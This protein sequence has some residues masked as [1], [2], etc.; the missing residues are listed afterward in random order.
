MIPARSIATN[1]TP[2]VPLIHETDFKLKYRM[3]P[4]PH[5]I[6]ASQFKPPWYQYLPSTLVI[7]ANSYCPLRITKKPTK[8]TPMS[9]PNNIPMESKNVVNASKKVANSSGINETSVA[10]SVTI[11]NAGVSFNLC[12]IFVSADPAAIKLTA[13]AV[14]DVI[15]ITNKAIIPKPNLDAIVEGSESFGSNE[16]FI[17]A[18]PMV[19]NRPI[20]A[21]PNNPKFAPKNAQPVAPDFFFA[22]LEKSEDAVTQAKLKA[23]RISI[24]APEEIRTDVGGCQS[25]I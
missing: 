3:I 24:A 6:I 9:G 17:T 11:H 10:I 13:L 7:S 18:V 12:H 16:L 8:N 21:N 23:A 15:I 5:E 4:L 2:I 19:A 14:V 20:K 22:N 25:N 1:V